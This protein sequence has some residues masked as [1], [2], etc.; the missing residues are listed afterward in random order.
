[1][2]GPVVLA[3]DLGAP[4]SPAPRTPVIVSDERP[5]TDWVQ[6][7]YGKPLEFMTLDS[8]RP[9]DLEMRPFYALAHNRYAVYFDEFSEAQWE[10]QQAAYRLEEER[11][12]DLI[13]R[14]VDSIRIGEM[15]PERDHDMNSEKNDVRGSNGRNFRTPL[16]GGWMEFKMKVDPSKPSELVMTYWGNERNRPEFDILIDGQKLVTETLPHQKNNQFFDEEHAIPAEMTRGKTTLIVRIQ[17]IPG[18][19]AGSVAGARTV[20]SKV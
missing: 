4:H 14:T 18:H 8:G 7:V 15:Q 12:K 10:Q 19:P 13:A 20:R 9:T 3:A 17:A 6:P 11:Q 5:V 16:E 2:Y 1:M